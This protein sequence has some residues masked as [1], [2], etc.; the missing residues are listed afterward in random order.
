MIDIFFFFLKK[1]RTC[2]FKEK[3]CDLTLG[4]KVLLIHWVSYMFT[5]YCW[6]CSLPFRVLLQLWDPPWQ[7]VY[8]LLQMFRNQ[9]MF[10]G[11]L[12]GHVTTSLLSFRI[13]SDAYLCGPV[14]AT[15]VFEKSGGPALCYL[16]GV[17]SLLC[18]VPLALILFLPLLLLLLLYSSLN[19]KG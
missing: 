6:A 18:S 2:K 10:W 16:E 17:D 5:I 12:Q 4:N 9:K 1:K 14:H 3:W 8:F 11:K 13:S 7:K 19:Y 15:T